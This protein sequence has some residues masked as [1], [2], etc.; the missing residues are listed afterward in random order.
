MQVVNGYV[1]QSC[2]DVSLAH[3]GVD[4]AHPEENPKSPKYNPQAATT[5]ND[6]IVRFGGA[7]AGVEG[8]YDTNSN[9]S[10]LQRPPRNG[11][12]V[13]VSA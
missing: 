12:L 8:A 9:G 6:P 11:D 10:N 7:L 2:S 3:Q 13:N 5:R 4:P 1:C